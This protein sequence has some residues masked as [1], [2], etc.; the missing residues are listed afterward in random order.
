MQVS[1]IEFMAQA[2]L[3][4]NRVEC[5]FIEYKKSAEQRASILKTACAYANNYMNR[6]IGLSSLGSRSWTKRMG[7]RQCPSIPFLA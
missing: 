1:N 6:E 5:D 4:L 2:I 3:E 7:R